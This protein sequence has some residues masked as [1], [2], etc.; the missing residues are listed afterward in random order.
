MAMPVLAQT[1]SAKRG[2][3]WDEKMQTIS[4]APIEKLAPGVSWLYNWGQKPNGDVSGLGPGRDIEYVPMCWNA[5][6][7]ETELRQWL[8]DNPGVKYLLGFNE[9]NFSAQ[10]NMTPAQAA[11]AW[12]KLEQIANDF[13]LRLVAPA[14]NFTGEKVGG[15][16]WSP[17]EWLDEFLRIYP[18]AK[19][20]CLALH[21]YMNWFSASTWFATEYFY[22]DLYD[23]Q[24]EAYGRYPNIVKYL[25]DYKAANGHFP[26]MMLTEFC[27]WEN[28]GTVTGTDF[29]IDQMTQKVQKLEQSDLVEGY[30]WFMAT[31]SA[32]AYPYY[33]LFESNSPS[34]ALSTLG[35]V[36][37]NMS[38]FD[39]DKFYTTGELIQAKDYTDASTDNQQ[40]RL[41]PNTESGSE[42]PLQVEM[43]SGSWAQY[44]L[45]VPAAGDYT[46]T[47]H[48]CSGTASNVFFYV[49]GKKQTSNTLASTGGAWSDVSFS[50]RIPSGEHSVM[51][52]NAGTEPFLINR[53]RLDASSTGVSAP[54]ADTASCAHDGVEV[55]GLDGKRIANAKSLSELNLERGIYIVLTSE[56]KRKVNVR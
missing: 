30:A 31:G 56:G 14:L 19:F 45:S 44:Q 41:R 13:D 24:N 7:N 12:A 37:V 48:I 51:I 50:T 32:S 52:Y 15:R 16:T 8:T 17:Y 28:D 9:P 35:T 6:Y 40:V 46:V 55:Y 20:D 26:R 21:C 53:F 22:K 18:E 2:I 3:G 1:K 39:T 47:M 29:Q 38:S 34:S 33:S 54:T 36:Y 23:E 11:E 49:D 27:S 5:G 4:S 10:A 43:Q 25:D 42:L